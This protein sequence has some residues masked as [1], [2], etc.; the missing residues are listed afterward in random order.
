MITTKLIMVPFHESFALLVLLLIFQT[1]NK[2]YPD[3]SLHLKRIISKIKQF[4]CLR[5]P[6]ATAQRN[7]RI[8]FEATP[9]TASLTCHIHTITTLLTRNDT[10]GYKPLHFCVYIRTSCLREVISPKTPV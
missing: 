5:P 3:I 10:V 4:S 9:P 8:V 6:A 7:Y 2:T 1:I